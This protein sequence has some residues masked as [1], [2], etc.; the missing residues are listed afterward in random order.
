MICF[1]YLVHVSIQLSV[2]AASRS[3]LRRTKPLAAASV[4]SLGSA[5]SYAPST[6]DGRCLQDNEVCAASAGVPLAAPVRQTLAEVCQEDAGDDGEPGSSGQ[7]PPQEPQD[8]N[9]APVTAVTSG[10][11]LLGQQLMNS[12]LGIIFRHMICI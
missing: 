7:L 10:L 1:V 8:H 3:L 5:L 12:K 11:F 4:A 6:E 2:A 9:G